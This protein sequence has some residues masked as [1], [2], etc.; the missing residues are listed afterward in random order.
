LVCCSSFVVCLLTYLSGGAAG[1]SQQ[2]PVIRLT[3]DLVLVDVLAKDKKTGEAIADLNQDDFLLRDNGKPVSLT[4]FNRGKDHNLRPVQLW[5]VMACNEER[6]YSTGGG[7]GGRW[8]PRPQVDSTEKSGSSFL[9]G[10]AAELRPALE[11]LR[12]EETV[13]VAHW[14]DDGQSEI[15]AVPSGDR[16][17]ALQAMDQVA[18]RKIVTIDHVPSEDAQEQVTRLINNVARTA[19]PEPFLGLVL[20]SGKELE[21]TVGMPWAT[22]SDFPK[23]S[24]TESGRAGGTNSV[25]EMGSTSEETEYVNRL[26]TFIDS[27]HSRYELGFEPGKHAKKRHNISVTLTKSAKERYPDVLLSYREAYSDAASAD[28]VGAAKNAL[29]WRQL[30]SRMQ[31]AV[32]SPANN[33]ELTFDAQRTRD[34]QAQTDHY[35]LRVAPSALTWETLPNGDRRGVVMAV[36][37]SYSAKGQLIWMMVKQLEIVQESDWLPGIGGKPVVLSLNAAVVKG[38]ARVRLVV[39]DV[40]T[41]HIGTQDLQTVSGP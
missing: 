2:A 11:H 7:G 34:S 33:S 18:A 6:H 12:P 8:A 31:S 10:K 27:L 26:G 13:G 1:S 35:V 17:A 3:T 22:L 36:V 38:A 23:G 15:D 19:F 40:V 4:R 21:S 5:F 14:C 37:A 25:A 30:D 32:K 39:R 16:A 28:D 9:A 24:T 29:D 41:G 20:V